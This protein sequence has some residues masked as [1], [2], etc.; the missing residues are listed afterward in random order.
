MPP[1]VQQR[2]DQ[3]PYACAS[4]PTHHS[5]YGAL[6]KMGSPCSRANAAQAATQAAPAACA[7]QQT[8][9]APSRKSSPSHPKS[10]PSSTACAHR[11]SQRAL[12]S[13]AHCRPGSC[14]CSRPPDARCTRVGGTQARPTA[15]GTHQARQTSRP[16]LQR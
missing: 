7:A 11:A 12:S 5:C 3:W 15:T 1:T 13:R 14:A 16:R 2:P 9:R 8:A 10:S 4:S 6:E